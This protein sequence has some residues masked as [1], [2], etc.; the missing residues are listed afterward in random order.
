MTKYEAYDR[1]L[2]LLPTIKSMV[3]FLAYYRLFSLWPTIV[4][5]CSAYVRMEARNFAFKFFGLGLSSITSVWSLANLQ[6][7]TF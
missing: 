6:K 3:D 4:T 2:S 7:Q 1:L 5:E